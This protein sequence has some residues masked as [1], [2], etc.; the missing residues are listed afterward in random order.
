MTIFFLSMKGEA[1]CY[2]PSMKG[3][4]DTLSGGLRVCPPTVWLCRD[5][6]VCPGTPASNTVWSGTSPVPE[7]L[8]CVGPVL[9]TGRDSGPHMVLSLKESGRSSQL[10]PGVPLLLGPQFPYLSSSFLPSGPSTCPSLSLL[11]PKPLH[12]QR[13]GGTPIEN[14][15]FCTN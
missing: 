9:G 13:M 5:W 6:R 14:R 10:I 1:R 15:E 7:C 11:I 8:L 12:K 2:V 3:D 4:Q